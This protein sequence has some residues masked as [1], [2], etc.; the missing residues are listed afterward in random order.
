M[1]AVNAQ[2]DKM[3][4]LCLCYFAILRLFVGATTSAR[5]LLMDSLRNP[6]KDAVGISGRRPKLLQKC[7][8]ADM[9]RV[10]A[11]VAGACA[12]RRGTVCVRSPSLGR[13]Q[14][15]PGRGGRR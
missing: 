15:V 5:G 9:G 13:V 11:I 8:L 10:G 6:S 3:C 4:V 7:V 12:I 14:D 1:D 2:L